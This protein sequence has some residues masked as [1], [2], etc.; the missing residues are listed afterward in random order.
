MMHLTC[1][2]SK[3]LVCDFHRKQAWL[4]WVTALKNNVAH[5]KDHIL[6]LLNVSTTYTISCLSVT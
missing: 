4:R 1:A 3:V 5:D 2:E 6:Q